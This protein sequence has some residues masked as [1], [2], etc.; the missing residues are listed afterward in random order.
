VWIVTVRAFQFARR[1]PEVLLGKRLGVSLMASQTSLGCG[2]LEKVQAGRGMRSVA[3]HASVGLGC[4]KVDG[5]RLQGFLNLRVTT[6]AKGL[7]RSPEKRLGITGMR[8]M[9]RGAVVAG[10]WMG[11]ASW[12]HSDLH[13]VAGGTDIDGRGVE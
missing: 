7:N 10:R 3:L 12:R 9:A 2:L 11:R 8:L 6:D 4:W 1:E 5:L 13:V